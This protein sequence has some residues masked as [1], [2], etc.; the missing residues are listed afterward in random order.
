[1]NSVKLRMQ[2]KTVAFV[3]LVFDSGEPISV[4]CHGPWTLIEAGVVRGRKITSCAPRS[5]S[6]CAMQGPNGWTKKLWSMGTS[7]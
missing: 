3:K 4:I 6:I 7:F 2:P 5:R 1:M